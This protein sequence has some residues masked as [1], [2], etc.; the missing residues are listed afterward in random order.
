LLEEAEVAEPYVR[1]LWI[2]SALLLGSV[3]FAVVLA[4]LARAGDPRLLGDR[5]PGALNAWKLAGWRLGVP[6]L[7]LDVAKGFVPAA[8][9][10]HAWGLESLWT[11]A[12]AAAPVVGHVFSVFLRGRGGKGLATTFG[13]WTALDPPWAP[14]CLGT[15]LTLSRFSLRLSDARTVGLGFLALGA[16]VLRS[17]SPVLEAAWLANAVVVL[18]AYHGRSPGQRRL[19]R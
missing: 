17:G 3:P 8:V 15:A 16:V 5:N 14:V 18:Y 10:R 4:R 12:A 2:L 11:A 7:L 19:A 1:S 9:A 13:V 6:V